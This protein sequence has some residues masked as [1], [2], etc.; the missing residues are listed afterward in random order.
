MLHY[1]FDYAFE[2]G[3][4]IDYKCSGGKDHRFV[5]KLGYKPEMISDC[6]YHA[7]GLNG[8]SLSSYG[9]WGTFFGKWADGTS[10][11]IF[12]DMYEQGL[13]ELWKITAYIHDEN[14]EVQWYSY[15]EG[16]GW[17]MFSEKKKEWINTEDPFK[18][19]GVVGSMSVAEICK[20]L[21]EKTGWKWGFISESEII[22]FNSKPPTND[23][24]KYTLEEVRKILEENNE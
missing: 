5:E 6:T 20:A 12:L 23:Y 21:E 7:P 3:H 9:D 14:G 10:R 13:I 17:I 24:E 15:T 16:H 2:H 1:P 8:F 18:K 4:S 11:K 22:K 19:Y